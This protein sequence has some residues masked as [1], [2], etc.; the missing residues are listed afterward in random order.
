MLPS[1]S[2]PQRRAIPKCLRTPPGVLEFDVVQLLAGGTN[3]HSGVCPSTRLWHCCFLPFGQETSFLSFCVEDRDR[4]ITSEG[5]SLVSM[6]HLPS[7][8]VMST[9]LEPGDKAAKIPLRGVRSS[10]SSA[11]PESELVLTHKSLWKPSSHTLRCLHAQSD[12]P[13]W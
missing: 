2:Q 3:S 13:L 8:Y 6:Y 12:D 5:S 11:L 9:C 7:S 1:G 4:V 10:P